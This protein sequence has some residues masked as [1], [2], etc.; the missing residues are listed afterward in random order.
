MQTKQITLSMKQVLLKSAIAVLSLFYSA[1][2]AFA[3]PEDHGRWYS[4]DDD[5]GSSMSPFGLIVGGI[6]IAFLS[7]LML[8]V[9]ESKKTPFYILGL[10][11]GIFCVIFG[12]SRC[13]G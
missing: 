9:D 5:E 4:L 3:G 7:Y 8:R 1:L 10:L 11:F 12:F 13:C 2:N 6:V